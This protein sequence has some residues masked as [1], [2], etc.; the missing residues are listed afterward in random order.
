MVVLAMT[1]KQEAESSK[2]SRCKSSDG[3]DSEENISSTPT[4]GNRDEKGTPRRKRLREQ[5]KTACLRCKKRKGKV[6]ASS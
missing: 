3:D 2:S 1:F 6:S 5:T 4:A